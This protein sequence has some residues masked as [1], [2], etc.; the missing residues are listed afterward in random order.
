MMNLA[1]NREQQ[2]HRR[3]FQEGLMQTM[4]NNYYIAFTFTQFNQ[5]TGI[6]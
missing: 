3:I 4:D 5:Q 2:S 1:L 6:L